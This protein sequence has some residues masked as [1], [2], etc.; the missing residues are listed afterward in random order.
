MEVH[1]L[2]WNH[3]K[4]SVLHFLFTFFLSNWVLAEGR[5]DDDV[6][7]RMAK[8]VPRVDN[9]ET[10]SEVGLDQF[11]GDTSYFARRTI[12]ISKKSV[13]DLILPLQ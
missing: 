13:I 8:A 12:R 2:G 3:Y 9:N 5:V 1:Q 6:E 7:N 11:F 4:S 10:K